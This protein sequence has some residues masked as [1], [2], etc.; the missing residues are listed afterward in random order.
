MPTLFPNLLDFNLPNPFSL[1]KTNDLTGLSSRLY[2]TGFNVCLITKLL[3]GIII[4][5]PLLWMKLPRIPG[6]FDDVFS[7]SNLLFSKAKCLLLV[8]TAPSLFTP[9]YPDHYVKFI[10]AFIS[11]ITKDPTDTIDPIKGKEIHSLRSIWQYFRNSIE[12]NA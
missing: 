7:F 12:S 3:G 6:P 9:S 5:A 4:V 10:G 2:H 11:N 1:F 8:N